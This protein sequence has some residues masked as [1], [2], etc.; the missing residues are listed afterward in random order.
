MRP[1]VC[2]TKVATPSANNPDLGDPLDAQCNIAAPVYRYQYRTLTNAFATY[3]PASPPAAEPIATTT[4][5]EG[6]DRALHRPHRA[7]RHQPRQ[8][9]HRHLA[10]PANPTASWQ[11]WSVSPS[12]NRKLFWSFGSGC[13]FGR[14]QANPGSVLDDERCAA[15]SWSRRPR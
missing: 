11:P 14:T 8:V 7:R 15:A 2:T 13:E 3:D 9:R 5:D 6:R 1:W 4:T 12:W 10:N